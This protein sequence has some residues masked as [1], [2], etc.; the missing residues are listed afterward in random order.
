MGLS[1]ST[2]TGRLPRVTPPER[3]LAEYWPV[4]GLRLATPRLVLTPLQDDDLVETLDLILS[5]IHDAGRMPFAM[6]WTDVPRAELIPNT[7]RYYWSSRGATTAQSWRLPFMVRCAGVLVGLQELQAKDFAVTKRVETGSWL[8]AAHQG[9]GLGTEMRE[10]VLQ[11]A[12]DHL[13]ATRADSAAFVDNPRSLRVSEKLGYTPDGTAVVQRRPGERAV[14]Q[15]LT[16]AP[17]QLI[18]SNWAVQVRGLP[19]CRDYF[20]L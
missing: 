16:L 11:F 2:A 4:F 3:T 14:E 6:P 9:D 12:F 20:G 19:L 5:G 15:R 13:K 18:R 7:L 10:A 17:G 1:V 8:G